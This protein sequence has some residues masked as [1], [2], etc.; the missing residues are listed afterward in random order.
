M[1]GNQIAF[2]VAD[3]IAQ[4]GKPGQNKTQ[5]GVARIAGC[6]IT[7]ESSSPKGCSDID[8]VY[9]ISGEGAQKFRAL[10]DRYGFCPGK[11][12]NGK[13]TIDGKERD[14]FSAMAGSPAI[15]QILDALRNASQSQFRS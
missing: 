15:Q 8:A 9:S 11:L 2:A 7:V 1:E 13:F 14:Q 12:E 10:C 3:A 5:G 4:C 6:T